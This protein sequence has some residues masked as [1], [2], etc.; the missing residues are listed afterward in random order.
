LQLYLRTHRAIRRSK[1]ASRKQKARTWCPS[2]NG[3]SQWRIGRCRATGKVIYCF[4]N[5]Q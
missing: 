3:R 5:P 4:S 1:H 2:V